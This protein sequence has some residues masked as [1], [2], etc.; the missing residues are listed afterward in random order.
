MGLPL[1]GHRGCTWEV[2][3]M[4]PQAWNP[5][6]GVSTA[7]RSL[8][9]CTASQGTGTS[10]LCVQSLPPVPGHPRLPQVSISYFLFPALPPLATSV[11]LSEGC[12]CACHFLQPAACALVPSAACLMN[13]YAFCKALSSLSLPCAPAR[14]RGLSP[15]RS[16]APGTV[17]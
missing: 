6:H 17:S 1:P 2:T 4:P 13:S 7:L 11:G 5:G 12:L 10:G 16:G 8:W 3:W 9:A 14:C 15:P